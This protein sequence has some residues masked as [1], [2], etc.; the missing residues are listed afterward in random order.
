MRSVHA[1]CSAAEPSSSV[2][3]LCTRRR[4]LKQ[5]PSV[6]G[7][8]CSATDVVPTAR[9]PATVH[10][11][12]AQCQGANRKGE[13]MRGTG[14]SAA[15]HRIERASARWDPSSADYPAPVLTPI[16]AHSRASPSSARTGTTQKRDAVVCTPLG[17]SWRPREPPHAP[18]ADRVTPLRAPAPKPRAQSTAGVA[19]CTAGE[20]CSSLAVRVGGSRRC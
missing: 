20:T 17:A 1:A 14:G 6:H 4:P 5:P 19:P 12:A 15:H 9:T 2:T 16:G 18:H 13:K 11:E 10:P 8:V 7:N 3:S